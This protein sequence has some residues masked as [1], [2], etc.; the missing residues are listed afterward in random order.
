MV[1]KVAGCLM[2]LLAGTL[3]GFYYAKRFQKR[4]VELQDLI[5]ALTSLASY[6]EHLAMPLT[7]ALKFSVEGLHGAVY[8][9]FVF[10]AGQMKTK[11]DLSWQQALAAAWEQSRNQ[12]SL[13]EPERHI[14]FALAANLPVLNPNGYSALF[15]TTQ[16]QLR[17]IEK[18]ALVEREKNVKLFRYLGFCGSLTV[19]ILLL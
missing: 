15:Q 13:A 19:V 14:L 16:E 5:L 7:S 10:T 12:L 4:V 9:L 11:P 17:E 18:Q 6:I 3:Q 1:L 2:I 8:D